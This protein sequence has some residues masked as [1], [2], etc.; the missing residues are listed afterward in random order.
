MHQLRSKYHYRLALKSSLK[1]KNQ[2]M[3][4]SSHWWRCTKQSSHEDPVGFCLKGKRCNYWKRNRSV[5][6]TSIEG[7]PRLQIIMFVVKLRDSTM[8]YLELTFP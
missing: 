7:G 1:E 8:M 6:M 4:L 5:S 2:I 3:T